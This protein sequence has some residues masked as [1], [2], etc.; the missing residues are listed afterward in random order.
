MSRS[1]KKAP[2]VE[3]KLYSRVD[4][5]M[6]T[7]GDKSDAASMVLLA[8]KYN[9]FTLRAKFTELCAMVL[10]IIMAIVFSIIG[11]SVTTS[12]IAAFWQVI[13]CMLLRAIS[14]RVFLNQNRETEE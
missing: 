5:T 8:K 7:Y 9:D 6:V 12:I 4:A 13:P 2:Y 14:Y 3:E 11:A 1:L 10:G